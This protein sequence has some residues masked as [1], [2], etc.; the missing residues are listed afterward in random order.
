[1]SFLDY[2]IDRGF[3]FYIYLIAGCTLAGLL[4]GW[5]GSIK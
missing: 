1:M 2:C 4:V 5:Y 3:W